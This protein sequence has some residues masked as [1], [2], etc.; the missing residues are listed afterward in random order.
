VDSAPVQEAFAMSLG[1]IPY[2]VLSDFEPKGAVTKAYGVY[3]DENGV[4]KRSVVIVDKEGIVRQVHFYGPGML[5]E[6]AEILEEV[7]AL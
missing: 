6:P 5:P 3:N 4:P 7:K 2:P 1:K